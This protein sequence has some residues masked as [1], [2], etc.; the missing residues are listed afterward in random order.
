M[1]PIVAI[2]LAALQLLG[3]GQRL[4]LGLRVRLG[5]GLGLQLHGVHRV[6]SGLHGQ[7]LGQQ[8]IAGIALRRLDELALLALTSD[9]LLKN[10]FHR[11][12]LLMVVYYPS[13]YWSMAAMSCS[14]TATTVPSGICPPAVVE[15]PPPPSFSIIICT[16]TAPKLRAEIQ[17][18][19][20][21]S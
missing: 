1:P 2:V 4:R 12:I 19:P 9:V 15:F 16:L 7:S 21:L 11:S 6:G 10:N 13:K 20:T 14:R 5:L 18:L 3:N 8:E 17:I